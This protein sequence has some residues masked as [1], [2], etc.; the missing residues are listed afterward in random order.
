VENPFF[1]IIR[2]HNPDYSILF[3]P[4]SKTTAPTLA[5]QSGKSRT[6]LLLCS[7]G[8]QLTPWKAVTLRPIEED[9]TKSGR[10]P[11]PQVAR[12]PGLVAR[13]DG[14]QTAIA[15]LVNQ[16]AFAR[17]TGIGVAPRFRLRIIFSGKDSAR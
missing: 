14:E 12:Q 16:P 13:N 8:K 10:P 15:G 3:R 11:S 4:P 17:Q 2:F 9:G 5:A 7:C 6:F 1:S